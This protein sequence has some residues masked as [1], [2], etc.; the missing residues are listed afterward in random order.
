[1]NAIRGYMVFLFKCFGQKPGHGRST[2]QYRAQVECM[3]DGIGFNLF[4]KAMNTI[5]N[6]GGQGYFFPFQTTQQT[7]SHPDKG[8]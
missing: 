2:N 5:G 8:T 3:L 1:M 4:N 6:T 7:I